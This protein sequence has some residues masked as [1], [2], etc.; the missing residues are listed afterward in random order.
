MNILVA[1]SGFKESLEPHIAADCIEKGILR[2]VPD[3]RV[4]KVPLFDGGE[5]FARA[6]VTA[7]DG[8][9]RQRAVTGPVNSPT[10]A[11]Y[12][13]IGDER[14]R[15]A[16]I[17]IAEA[18][19]LRLVPRDKRDPTRTTT[20]GVGELIAA[21]LDQGA[22]QILI[23]CG[24]SGTSDG[25]VGMCQ[26]LG[27]KFF[28]NNGCELPLASGGA[29]LIHLAK[30]DLSGMHPRLH[31]VKIDVL[32]NWKNVLCGPNGVARVYGPQKGATAD[33]VI[34]L[35]TALDIYAAAVK[36]ATGLEVA[37]MPGGG[38]SGGLGAG[39]ALIGA[40]LRP[41]FE[42]IM[43]YFGIEEL[44]DGCQL[45]FTA[46]GGIDYQ[47]PRGKIPGEV[48]LRAKRRGI[49]VVAIAGTI[50][51]GATVNYDAGIDAFTSM[52]QGPTSLEEAVAHAPELLSE[53]AEAA[54]RMI[55][56]GSRIGKKVDARKSPIHAK[57][58]FKWLAQRRNSFHAQISGPFLK[59]LLL[60]T[61]FY[62]IFSRSWFATER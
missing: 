5:G 15:T 52:I 32:C 53:S 22:D 61:S 55:M 9:H 11:Y 25:G 38:A 16:V 28:D 37:T 46:E 45:V 41:R 57:D 34:Q 6:L 58:A 7:T 13:F 23:G 24:D 54:M 27:I 35:A 8:E 1:P 36:Q 43:E 33:Q 19:G 49:P 39:F 12:G 14:R 30:I 17:E 3:A 31:E 47:T 20:Y 18:A 40:T 21:A 44:F 56:I 60:F 42:A 29:S 10:E 48:A 51:T 2:V 62:L 26:A 4:R 59:V 50:G